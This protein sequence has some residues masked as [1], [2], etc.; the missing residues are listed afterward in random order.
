[1]AEKYHVDL[2]GRFLLEKSIMAINREKKKE[3]V[4]K[5][6]NSLNA[7]KSMVFVNFHGL[8]VGAVDE[9]RRALRVAKIGYF[10]AKKNLIGLALDDAKISGERPSFPGELALAYGDDLVAP[11]REIYEFQKK[12]PDNIKIVG[13]IFDGKYMDLVAMNEIAAIPPLPIIHGKFVNIINSPI[14]RFVIGLSQIAV[15]KSE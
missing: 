15:A 6:K 2:C 11:A 8:T 4:E 5:V 12:N 10:V 14:Q 3:I 9:L 1:L 13:G 7:S